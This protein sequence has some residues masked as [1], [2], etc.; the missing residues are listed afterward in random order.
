MLEF[1]LIVVIFSTFLYFLSN[2]QACLSLDHDPQLGALGLK[3]V[4]SELV[5]QDEVAPDLGQ[6][7]RGLHILGESLHHVVKLI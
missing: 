6:S 4:P 2:Y 5:L 1:K 7:H 3:A